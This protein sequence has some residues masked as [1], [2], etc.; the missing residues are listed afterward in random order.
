MKVGFLNYYLH[1]SKNKCLFDP[2]AHGL[3]DNLTYPY[4]H[5]YEK[6]KSKGIEISTFDTEFKKL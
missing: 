4:V 2:E 1:C 6:A 5:L 3:G